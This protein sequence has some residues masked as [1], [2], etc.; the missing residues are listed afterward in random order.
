MFFLFEI[1]KYDLNL[2]KILYGYLA[3]QI[4]NAS[5]RLVF[6]VSTYQS[7]VVLDDE[8]YVFSI[9]KDKFD[10]YKKPVRYFK[11]IDDF[12]RECI[13]MNNVFFF[14]DHDLKQKLN[15][16]ELIEKN[17]IQNRSVLLTGNYDD[18]TIQQK[19]TQ[20][21]IKILPKPLIHYID[22]GA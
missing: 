2:K 12:E 18:K 4:G 3:S 22:V 15:G 17:N 10:V 14:V 1:K 19:S 20:S 5:V 16:I 21:N 13:T 11:R 9:L 8:E 6:D 7:I